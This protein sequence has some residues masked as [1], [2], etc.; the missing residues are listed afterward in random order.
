MKKIVFIA[1]FSLLL[2]ACPQTNS[3]MVLFNTKSVELT[4]PKDLEYIKKHFHL[5]RVL[6]NKRS[7]G[8]FYKTFNKKELE[9]LID[10]LVEKNYIKGLDKNDTKAIKMLLYPRVKIIYIPKECKIDS[11]IKKYFLKDR[12]E[13]WIAIDNN[14][15]VRFDKKGCARFELL[16]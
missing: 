14:I 4:A 11:K 12:I 7:F 15:D 16:R 2:Y 10:N 3:I 1:I 9:E 13:E 8:F 6:F 5:E